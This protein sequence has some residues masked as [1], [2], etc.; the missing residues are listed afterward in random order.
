MKR[1][2]RTS[3]KKLL[4]QLFAGNLIIA[5]SVMI[6]MGIFSVSTSKL[7]IQKKFVNYNE[8][9]LK[10]TA[11]QIDS[12]FDRILKMPL[13]INDQ[14]KNINNLFSLAYGGR[15]TDFSD[16]FDDF[17]GLYADCDYIDS[18]W[19]YDGRSYIID[20]KTGL[21]TPDVFEGWRDMMNMT[22][23]AKRE[24]VYMLPYISPA[25]ETENA[26]NVISVVSPLRLSDNDYSDGCVVINVNMPAIVNNTYAS[27]N[28]EGGFCIFNPDSNFVISRMGDIKFSDELFNSVSYGESEADIKFG[29]KRYNVHSEPSEMLNGYTY[30][31]ANS[32]D[33][34]SGEITGLMMNFILTVIILAAVEIMVSLWISKSIY[35]P[36]KQLLA[37]M[38]LL[39]FH[40]NRDG[41][42]YDANEFNILNRYMSELQNDLMQKNQT[43]DSHMPV[44]RRNAG[45]MI[46]EGNFDDEAKIHAALR[47][48]GAEMDGTR[49]IMC[50][51]MI[52]NWLDVM[53][54]QSEDDINAVKNAVFEIIEA[55]MIK[56]FK[57][58]PDIP[59]DDRMAFVIDFSEDDAGLRLEKS[60]QS[61]N[62]LLLL[63][64]SVSVSAA[65]SRPVESLLEVRRCNAELRELAPERF[66]HGSRSFIRSKTEVLTA[67]EANEMYIKQ[68]AVFMKAVA[69]HETEDAVRAADI[70]ADNLCLM[71]TDNIRAVIL[72]FI[73]ALKTKYGDM[74]E[75]EDIH[76]NI[77]NL[78]KYSDVDELKLRF[79]NII[80][81][82]ILSVP[83]SSDSVAV[84]IKEY[85]DCNYKKELSLQYLADV[86]R[87]SPAYLSTLFKNANGT[88]V[89]DYINRVRI[90]KAKELLKNTEMSIKDISEESGF[91]N[92]NSFARVFKKVTGISA[93][94]YKH[95][96]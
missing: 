90:N 65:Q 8:A 48:C 27:E 46:V 68:S 40:D 77:M 70:I 60:L 16:S 42:N 91:T 69:A 30:V 59:F 14:N 33:S 32:Y 36:L 3:K 39:F 95:N 89:V 62:D 88:G 53:S 75:L 10:Q 4:S 25:H 82:I 43:L 52:D 54:E 58:V 55:E 13:S 81:E 31:F 76:E 21:R 37:N 18:I 84:K 6:I 49:Y 26:L 28:E 20:T 11:T 51:F 15:L 29:G 78:I 44:I 34:I 83:S 47:D 56:N 61:I 22:E 41:R 71:S 80:S 96:L 92:Y 85:I 38:N 23:E 87:L 73:M 74:P 93:K 1:L 50:V 86:F 57:C 72:R 45:H 2:I 9:R 94:D 7:Y 64:M 66:K 67:A 24:Y 63:Q 12:Y 17:V 35:L 19:I 5:V 79:H